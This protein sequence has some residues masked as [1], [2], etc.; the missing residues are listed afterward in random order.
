[1]LPI[2][3][4][5]G[6]REW[7][8]GRKTDPAYDMDWRRAGVA[9]IRPRAAQEDDEL[10]QA[11]IDQLRRDIIDQ[12]RRDLGFSRDQILTQLGVPDPEGAPARL[13]PEQLAGIAP[14]RRVDV[15]F[16]RDQL[17]AELAAQRALIEAQA[18]LIEAIAEKV[19]VPL[20]PPEGRPS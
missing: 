12:L 11:Q 20:T 5:I 9:G 16:A 2:S 13:T 18:D 1:M 14:A 10:S 19:G 3:R 7:A 17:V 4:V 8:P 6:H 15:G